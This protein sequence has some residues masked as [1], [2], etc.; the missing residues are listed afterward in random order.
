MPSMRTQLDVRCA[1]VTNTLMFG[2]VLHTCTRSHSLTATLSTTYSHRHLTSDS[3][4]PT[5]TPEF[6]YTSP[7]FVNTTYSIKAYKGLSSYSSE[8]AI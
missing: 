6:G 8:L 7:L 5:P 4:T 3:A 2:I 1:V